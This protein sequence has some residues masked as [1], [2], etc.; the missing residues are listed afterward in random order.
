MFRVHNNTNLNIEAAF[1]CIRRSGSNCHDNTAQRRWQ[2]IILLWLSLQYLLWDS[3]SLKS[4]RTPPGHACVV[5]EHGDMCTAGQTF[6]SQ[7]GATL[8]E[9]PR[10][11]KWCQDNWN[12]K[13]H[14]DAMTTVA[15]TNLCS[16]CLHLIWVKVSLRVAHE[17]Q[18]PV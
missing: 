9:P 11:D 18:H 14:I 16:E 13:F 12:R 3:S 10:A 4:K 5:P 15:Q 1:C 2:P 7:S 17:H 8:A 6:P